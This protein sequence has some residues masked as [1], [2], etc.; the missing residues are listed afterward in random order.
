MNAGARYDVVIG[1][2]LVTANTEFS[3]LKSQADLVQD[4]DSI[5]IHFNLGSRFGR[6]YIF[7]TIFTGAVADAV[8]RDDRYSLTSAAIRHGDPAWTHLS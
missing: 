6:E 8:I 5:L 3:H 1:Q 4:N 7:V 2:R